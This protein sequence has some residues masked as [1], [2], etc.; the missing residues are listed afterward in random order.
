M[1]KICEILPTLSS[2]LFRFFS[3][4]QMM[5]PIGVIAECA[6]KKCMTAAPNLQKYNFFLVGIKLFCR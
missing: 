2:R 1:K 5:L 4:F 3:L 6:L